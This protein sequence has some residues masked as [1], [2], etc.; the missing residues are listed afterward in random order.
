MTQNKIDR[1][2]VGLTQIKPKHSI[3]ADDDDEEHSWLN[4]ETKQ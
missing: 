4:N 3:D 1:Q 2:R